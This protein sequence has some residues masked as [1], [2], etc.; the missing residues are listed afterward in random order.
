MP[1]SINLQ[2]TTNQWLAKAWVDQVLKDN[3]FFGEVLG[4]TEQ[5]E[6]SQMVHPFKYQKGVA[7][8]AFNGFDDLPTS[9]QPVTVNGVFYPTFKRIVDV[10]KSFLIYGEVPNYAFA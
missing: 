8:V 10:V 6:G 4:N 1:P 3:F 7:T 5:W 9:Q 2:A